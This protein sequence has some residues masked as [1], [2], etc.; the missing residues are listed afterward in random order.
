MSKVQDAEE[1]VC[2]FY[3]VENLTKIDEASV[4]L[5][6]KWKTLQALPPATDGLH[7]H[8]CKSPISEPDLET[9]RQG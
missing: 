6:N 5:F 2:K 3:R 8:Y 9:T 4:K 1:F 7:G